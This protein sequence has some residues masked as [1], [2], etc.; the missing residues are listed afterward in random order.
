MISRKA[1]WSQ[2]ILVPFFV[3]LIIVAML[4]LTFESR[5]LESVRPELERDLLNQRANSLLVSVMRTPASSVTM[6]DLIIR[7]T[8][9]SELNNTMGAM[10]ADNTYYQAF[11]LY[12]NGLLLQPRNSELARLTDEKSLVVDP[13]IRNVGTAEVL[14]P[15]NNG[16]IRVK[17]LLA[18]EPLQY[19]GYYT[20][21]DDEQKGM[22]YE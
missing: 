7:N 2:L 16:N 11:I 18:Q 12:P 17:L 5:Q 10:L 6:A 13:I 1:E 19:Y 9:E 20:K 4:L 14:L 8:Q 3:I 15:S 21:K 22:L